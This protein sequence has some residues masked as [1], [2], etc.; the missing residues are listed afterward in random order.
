MIT[1]GTFV[2]YKNWRIWV[3]GGNKM[4][5]ANRLKEAKEIYTSGYL[6]SPIKE[7]LTYLRNKIL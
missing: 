7:E 5:Y 1:E 4:D 6:Q 2:D 3:Y